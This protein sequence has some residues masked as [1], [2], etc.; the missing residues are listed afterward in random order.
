MARYTNGIVHATNKR[1]HDDV[2]SKV[3]GVDGAR[4][5]AAPSSR[6][7]TVD[8]KMEDVDRKME[9]G[10]PVIPDGEYPTTKQLTKMLK[11]IEGLPASSLENQNDARREST[12]TMLDEIKTRCIHYGDDSDEE[13]K[14]KQDFRELL[15][16]LG[17][18][19]RALFFIEEN[20]KDVD[21]IAATAGIL[22][23]LIRD[24][25]ETVERTSELLMENG[26]FRIFQ[27]AIEETPQSKKESH[28]KAVNILTS[29]IRCIVHDVAPKLDVHQLTFF[30]ETFF[31]YFDDA[32]KGSLTTNT[33][34]VA[35]DAMG[36]VAST[37]GLILNAHDDMTEVFKQHTVSRTFFQ[38]CNRHETD[39]LGNAN[40]VDN[41]LFLC[42]AAV[43]DDIIDDDEAIEWI[44]LI[45]QG[46]LKW[47]N[48]CDVESNAS[49]YIKAVIK[50][51]DHRKLEATDLIPS[52]HKLLKSDD[53][54]E[55]IKTKY[56]RFIRQ[57]MS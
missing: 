5:D 7:D 35:V 20:M 4:P 24:S 9:D 21:L 51:M 33:V 41:I 27:L 3:A 56:R 15:L 54:S 49:D 53:V 2:D 16:F 34:C 8:R 57:I 28:W 6:S 13:E 32:T 38:F 19:L 11:H 18:P 45:I 40:C 48:F 43:K 55:E 10:L 1:K 52:L 23:A 17:F 42:C 31:P 12:L 44:P 30:L 37:L 25:S 39:W 14:E 46:L 26:C 36:D 22:E 29:C 47:P 50:K